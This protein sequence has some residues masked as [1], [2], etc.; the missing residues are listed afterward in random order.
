MNINSRSLK[1]IIIT[2]SPINSIR[3]Y[4]TRQRER[5]NDFLHLQCQVKKIDSTKPLTAILTYNR[6]GNRYSRRQKSCI[7]NEASKL[8]EPK[9]QISHCFGV[10]ML[11]KSFK[12]GCTMPTADTCLLIRLLVY[13]SAYLLTYCCCLCIHL[14]ICLFIYRFLYFLIYSYINLSIYLFTY[15]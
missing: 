14:F 9:Q 11:H 3:R 8:S 6:L 2:I 1:I 15:S 5:R 10:Q 12:R 7:V 13:L 4:D